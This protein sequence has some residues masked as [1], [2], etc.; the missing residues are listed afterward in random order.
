MGQKPAETSPALAKGEITRRQMMRAAE[1]LFARDGLENVSVR[2]LIQAAGQKNESALQYHFGSRQ[3]LIEAIHSYRG[4]QVQRQ[5]AVMLQELLGQSN[6]PSLRELCTLM[7]GP[8]CRLAVVDPG[9]RDYIAVFGQK[10][11]LG[12]R[13]MSVQL[14]AAGDR[15]LARLRP[16]LRQHLQQWNEELFELRLEHAIRYASLAMSLQA[17]KTEGFA[18]ANAALFYHDLLDILA[19]ILAAPVAAE[20]ALLLQSGE[21]A[22]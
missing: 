6:N 16:L 2:A 12:E 22:V 21:G 15:S 14:A 17:N 9:F 5:R 18:D 7:V 8:A 13:K 1:T 11:A 4:G 3:G 19:A 10:V 20:T